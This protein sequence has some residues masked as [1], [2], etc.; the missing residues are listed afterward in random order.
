MDSTRIVNAKDECKMK[1]SFSISHDLSQLACV[2]VTVLLFAEVAVAQISA[3]GGVVK[4]LDGAPLSDAVIRIDRMDI[5]GRY[6]TKTN[7]NGRYFYNGLPLGRYRITCSCGGKHIDA[8]EVQTQLDDP[9]SVNFDLGATARKQ[10]E[11]LR[12]PDRSSGL[13]SV[14]VNAQNAADRLQLNTD[15]SFSLQEGGQSFTGTYSVAGSTLELHIAQLQKDVDI[16]VQG[17]KL[18]VNGEEIW[19][20]PN[21]VS[22]SPVAAPSTAAEGPK[23]NL[24]D[25]QNDIEAGTVVSIPVRYNSAVFGYVYM[26]EGVVTLSKT[27]FAFRGTVGANAFEVSP[28]KILQLNWQRMEY[29]DTPACHVKVAVKNKKGTKDDKKEYYFYSAGA[30]AVGGGP[31]GQGAS[32]SCS[33]CDDSMNVL[34]SLLTRVRGGQ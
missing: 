6:Q 13:G 10:E 14:Y 28:D 5:G 7:K 9:I 34:F 27:T 33:G 31:G 18:V 15:G 21:K 24:A 30:S 12:S 20:Q 32:I 4:G 22:E 25:P 8:V 29:S 2:I 23:G 26:A 16:L 3:V 11:P 1:N 17:A 19:T